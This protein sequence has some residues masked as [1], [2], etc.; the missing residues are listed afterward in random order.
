MLFLRSTS[1]FLFVLSKLHAFVDIPAIDT[2][3][4]THNELGIQLSLTFILR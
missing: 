3:N 1:F 2:N 4:F